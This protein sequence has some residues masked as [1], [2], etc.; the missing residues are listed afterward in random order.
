M[1]LAK[2]QG[3]SAL[4][5]KP[6]ASGCELSSEGLR[7]QDALLLQ[8]QCSKPIAYELINPFAFAPAIAPHIAAEQI[9]VTLNTGKLLA[10]VNTIISKKADFTLVEGAG[11]W[12]VPINQSELLSDLVQALAI[13]VVLVVGIKLG[14]ISH[15]LLTVE[16][17][18]RA[19]ISIVGWVANHVTPAMQVA[20]ENSDYLRKSLSIPCLGEVPYLPNHSVSEISTYIQLPKVKN[21]V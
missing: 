18:E 16:A 21:D 8:A 11:G 14:C 5:V 15:T 12:H 3:L 2:A 6:I 9:G 13:P 17:I 20:Q 7:N 10:A 1:H 4:A 19:G